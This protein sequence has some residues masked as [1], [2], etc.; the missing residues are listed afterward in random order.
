[1]DETLGGITTLY[2]YTCLRIFINTST[3][4]FQRYTDRETHGETQ[5]KTDRDILRLLLTFL[6]HSLQHPVLGMKHAV[7]ESPPTSYIHAPVYL[8]T[9]IHIPT[10]PEDSQLHREDTQPT[11]LDR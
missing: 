6:H 11:Q 1:M 10:N 7:A 9:H 5:T 4:Q 8:H 2:T 3:H